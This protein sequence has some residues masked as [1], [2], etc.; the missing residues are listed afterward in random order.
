MKRKSN[1]RRLN[2]FQRAFDCL[3]AY[4]ATKIGWLGRNLGGHIN[5]G[6]ITIYGA[7]AMHF[8]VNIRTRWGYVCFR[9]PLRCFGIWW[10]AYFYISRDATPFNARFKLGSTN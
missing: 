9:L 7:N 2:W 5:I 8:A 4:D 3:V 1:G 10:H 6:P